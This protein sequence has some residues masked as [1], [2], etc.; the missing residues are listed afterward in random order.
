MKI[1]IDTKEDSVSEI[2]R[3]INLL[4]SLIDS[5]V[6]S[7]ADIFSGLS[8]SGSRDMF[9]QPLQSLSN[10]QESSNQSDISRLQSA[11]SSSVSENKSVFGVFSNDNVSETASTVAE[12]KDDEDDIQNIEIVRY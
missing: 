7:N 3:V 6:R 4:S 12:R 11:P 1:T 10:S 2:K 9:G 8:S 5:G